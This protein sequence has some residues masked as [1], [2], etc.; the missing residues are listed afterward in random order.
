MAE[1]DGGEDGA[2]RSGGTRARR[3]MRGAVQ[4]TYLAGLPGR[5]GPVEGEVSVA[6]G[7][8]VFAGMREMPGAPPELVEADLPLEGV[9]ALSLEEVQ[10]GGSVGGVAALGGRADGIAEFLAAGGARSG[11]VLRLTERPA[12]GGAER[13]WAFALRGMDG[14]LLAQA[15]ERVG[16][17]RPP[18]RTVDGTGAQATPARAQVPAGAVGTAGG[19]PGPASPSAPRRA[20]AAGPGGDL[21]AEPGG[22]SGSAAPATPAEPTWALAGEAERHP[23]ATTGGGARDEGALLGEILA[24]LRAQTALLRRLAE[25]AGPG[26]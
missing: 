9:V 23:P 16:G 8:V 25:R 15:V 11:H 14:R 24:E 12:A 3:V 10:A 2:R 19:S 1:M 26:G 13:H 21:R 20:V 17:A 22:R 7:R 4:A 18:V 6:G 5:G